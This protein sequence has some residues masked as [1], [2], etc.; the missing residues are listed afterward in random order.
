[1]RAA[2]PSGRPL[3]LPVS[4][5]RRRPLLANGGYQMGRFESLRRR[6]VRVDRHGGRPVLGS[7]SQA[8]SIATLRSRMA[9]ED[10]TVMSL[11]SKTKS[12]SPVQGR[13]PVTRPT[14]ET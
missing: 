6:P 1:M 5:Y 4:F 12:P 11:E 3:F 8:F 7:R 14:K 10:P 9:N 2:Q 13:R